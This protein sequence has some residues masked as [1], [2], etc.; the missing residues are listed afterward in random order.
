[1]ADEVIIILISLIFS[2][3]FSGMEIAFIS[4][5]KLR[6]EVDRKKGVMGSK[7]ISFFS[8]NARQYI[9]TMLVGNNIA[10]VIYG[11][12][13]AI[14][15]EPLIIVFTRS[16][17]VILVVQ[18]IVSTLIILITAEFLPKTLFRINPNTALKVFMLPTLFFY[19]LLY[20]VTK[21]IIALSNLL[22]KAFRGFPVNNANGTNVFGKV[23]LNH[24]VS[25]I[26]YKELDKLDEEHEIRIFQ[27]ALDFSNVKLRDCMIPRTEIVA[28]EEN[29]SVEDLKQR[30]IETGLSKILIYKE[31][32]DNVIGYVNTRALF[33]N[34][35]EIPPLIHTIPIVP[36]SMPAKKLLESLIK[37]Q[38]SIALVVDEFGGTSGIVTIEDILE[39][40]FGEIEDEHDTILLTEEKISENEYMFSGRLEIDYLNDK[41][42]LDIPKKDEYETLAGF[43]LYH[44]ENI[45]SIN[46]RIEIESFIIKILDVSET[47]IELLQLTKKQA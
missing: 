36:E 26:Q 21:L 28:L 33:K 16:E 6:I 41:Y 12:V 47:R 42:R 20:P 44:Y 40:I 2:A 30:F 8:E 46:D 4:S 23:D 14:L 15:L 45:P 7:V 3:F 25:E 34:P 31:S 19:I 38:I 35:E 22:F 32:I 1:V 10:L 27:N 9:A 39:E 18:T 13:M 37:Q 5:N 11:I 17:S 24:L 29:C 43:I